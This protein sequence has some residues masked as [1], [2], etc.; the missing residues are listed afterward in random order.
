MTKR[1]SFRAERSEEPESRIK[2]ITTEK[3]GVASVLVF[4][5]RAGSWFWLEQELELDTLFILYT[6]SR[7]SR[8]MT[9]I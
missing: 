7:N 1:P 2:V 9:H 8:H 4:R 5:E 6:K 3:D